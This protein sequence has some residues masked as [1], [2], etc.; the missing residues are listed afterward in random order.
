MLVGGEVLYVGGR[1]L[2]WLRV[3][4]GQQSYCWTRTTPKTT[5]RHG[6]KNAHNTFGRLA[7]S[8]SKV[9]RAHRRL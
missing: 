3:V 7:L 6:L 9:G 8:D 4:D 5:F 2:C 1:K